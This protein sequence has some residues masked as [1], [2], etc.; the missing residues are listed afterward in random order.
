[1]HAKQLVHTVL[2][3]LILASLFGTTCSLEPDNLGT[4]S[5]KLIWLMT[6]GEDNKTYTIGV[7]DTE[8][9]N[10]N[11]SSYYNENSK[12]VTIHLKGI[13]GEQII[14]GEGGS[15]LSVH[16]GV[17]LVLDADITVV[18]DIEVEPGGTLIMN[19]GS[20]VTGGRVNVSRYGTF[21]MNGGTISGNS[22][23]SSFNDGGG[24][25]L[26]S[27]GIFTMN[28][29]TISGNS[30]T[31]GDGGAVY[32][33]SNG[34]FTMNGGEISGNTTNTNSFVT[35]STS[36]SGSGGGVSVR[37]GTFTMN[38]GEISGNTTNSFG[39]GGGV[40]VDGNG[41]FT[42][43]GGTISGNIATSNGGGVNVRNGT[44][45]MNDGTISGNSSSLGSG[46]GVSTDGTF[47]MNDGTIS[48]NS[49]SFTGGGVSAGGT[50]T[51][52]GGKISGNNVSSSSYYSVSG[53]GVSADGTFTMSGGEISSN[54]VSSSHYSYY[55]SYYYSSSSGGGVS[56]NGTFEMS[57]GTISGNTA[58][59]SLP[60]STS[61]PNL[62]Y[63]SS[64]SGGGVYVR[65]GTFEMSGG[66][67]S[68]NTAAASPP[69]TYYSYSTNSSGG[70]VYVDYDGIFIK[71][72][73]T[74]YGYSAGD[75][76]NSNTVKNSSGTAD[77]ARGNAV[78]ALYR[79][80]IMSQ[81]KETTAGPEQN[82]SFN[83]NSGSFSGGW[84][85]V[86]FPEPI[87]LTANTW[88]DGS[89]SSSDS[90][91]LYSIPSRYSYVWWNDADAG[92]GKT[93]DIRVSAFLS[94]GSTIFA[95]RDRGWSS[96][97]DLNN[98]SGNGTVLI[99][100]E[101]YSSG[102]TGTFAIAY[103]SSGSTRPE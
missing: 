52:N 82:L 49:S 26:S 102:D 33:G 13:G 92:Q 75:T 59:I 19:N 24:V 34:T 16:N 97:A 51:M 58:A 9:I 71:T 32:V 99:L 81:R 1:M 38:G 90:V 60:I 66:T 70:G 91:V 103:N 47:I 62:Y 94:G 35:W 61:S 7:T 18:G 93:L 28:S 67:I 68:G 40:S 3:T 6:N 86:I 21:T 12:A 76:V 48:S 89:I 29:G 80:P 36:S 74:I 77:N 73:G 87:P 54:N 78:Y 79:N 22:N 8:Q 57:G 85:A 11:Y 65:N 98:V 25:Y 23:T 95:S 84:D 39:G 4:L 45:I 5:Y 41:T 100:V 44:F 31:H 20:G 46:G 88:T 72:N 69:S 55:G 101:P 96:P 14:K 27:N 2:I 42:M 83:G 53:G 17:T 15:R 43:S 10:V 30:V 64:S 50:F 37:S 63:Y 56:V